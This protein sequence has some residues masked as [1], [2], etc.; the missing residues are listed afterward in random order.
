MR[1]SWLRWRPWPATAGDPVA[2]LAATRTHIELYRAWMDERGLAPSTVDRRLLRVCG[3]YRFT[4]IDARIV[5]VSTACASARPAGRTSRT[6]ASNAAIAPCGSSAARNRPAGIP[7]VPRTARTVDLAIGERSEGPILLRHDGDRLDTRTAFRWARAVGKQ[8]GLERI[9][10]HI[11]RAA[12]IMAALDAGVP[13]RDVQLAARH[14]DPRGVEYAHR[15]GYVLVS[16]ESDFNDLAFVHGPPP[17]VIGLR[18]GN[19]SND[20]LRNCSPQPRTRSSPSPRTNRTPCSNCGRS[21]A[22]R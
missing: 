6:L 18:V 21:Q 5:S 13:L 3:H 4:H 14:A 7:L 10:P 19:A 20:A 9:H 16:K 1:P 11:L 15:H 22:A 2:A 17:K 12:F 8:A